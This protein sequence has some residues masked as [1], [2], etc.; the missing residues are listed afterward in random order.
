[1]VM[2]GVWENIPDW[3]DIRQ[4]K[5]DMRVKCRTKKA[6]VNPG[7]LQWLQETQVSVI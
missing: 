1:M 6:A 4:D 5:A 3:F 7:P 2:E